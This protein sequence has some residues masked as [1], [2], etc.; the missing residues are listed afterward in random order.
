MILMFFA[1]F[2]I[3]QTSSASLLAVNRDMQRF[4]GQ[5]ADSG[6][7]A[8]ILNTK[9]FPFQRPASFLLAP[10][11]RVRSLFSPQNFG[12]CGITVDEA[13]PC[14]IVYPLGAN[15]SSGAGDDFMQVPREK[16]GVSG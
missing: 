13:I 5:V 7:S 3:T 9:E 12:H 14:L 8:A 10:E 1:T 6:C 2:Q 16:I 15:I 4:S 11:I